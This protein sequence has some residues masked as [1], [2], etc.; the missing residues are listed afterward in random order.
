ML[1]FALKESKPYAPA[2]FE[3][4][5]DQLALPWENALQPKE[6]PLTSLISVNDSKESLSVSGEG[7]EYRFGK[8]DG[9]LQS[10]KFSGKELIQEGP[11]LNVWRAP[12]ANDLD[13]W[14]SWAANLAKGKTGMGTFPAGIWFTLGLDQLHFKLDQFRIVSSEMDKVVVEV[15]DHAEGSYYN[16]AFDNH[17]LY[18]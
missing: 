2:G 1:S 14:A 15:I 18:I 5:W 9:K 8:E 4:A 17:Y 3:V 16:T 11:K 12:L 13:N 10:M 7:F 6:E